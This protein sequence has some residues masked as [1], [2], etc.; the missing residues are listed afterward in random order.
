MRER[1]KAAL[2]EGVKNIGVLPVD[3]VSLKQP[4]TRQGI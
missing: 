3:T 1:G 4:A 2:Q